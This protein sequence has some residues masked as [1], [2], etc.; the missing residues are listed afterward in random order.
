MTEKKN[1]RTGTLCSCWIF[2]KH[3]LL[4][5]LLCFPTQPSP[6]QVI[7]Y[8]L[9]IWIVFLSEFRLRQQ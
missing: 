8:Y 6:L 7:T 4:T 2:K 1:Q 3:T 9:Q 5:L